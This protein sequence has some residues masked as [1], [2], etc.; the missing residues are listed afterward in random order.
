MSGYLEKDP[1]N[2]PKKDNQASHPLLTD[3]ID[4][5]INGKRPEWPDGVNEISIYI[6]V[7]QTD[8][9]N[10]GEIRSRNLATSSLHK[11]HLPPVRSLVELW[12]I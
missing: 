7:P 1:K 4:P 8:W 12:E 11:S 6:S 9:F 5:L 10:Q 2:D 3:E